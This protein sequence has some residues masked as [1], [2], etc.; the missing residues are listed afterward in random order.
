MYGA[1][2]YG[3]VPY[4]SAATS[5]GVYLVGEIALDP[6]ASITAAHGI[7]GPANIVVETPVVQ[8]GADQTERVSTVVVASGVAV[9]ATSTIPVY[10]VGLI[11]PA[12]SV[13]SLAW[14]TVRG[15][16]AIVAP[17]STSILCSQTMPITSNITA[18]VR[19][20]A[21]VYVD[22]AITAAIRP[23]V[24]AAAEGLVVTHGRGAV[25]I[26]AYVLST[27]T[28]GFVGS[29]SAT[30]RAVFSATA[31][32]SK[33]SDAAVNVPASVAGTINYGPSMSGAI[34]PAI[35]FY[36]MAGAYSDIQI[37]G[38]IIVPVSTYIRSTSGDDLLNADC[39]YV[40]TKQFSVSVLQ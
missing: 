40:L 39:A 6:V 11:G 25:T 30:I 36:A 33:M 38:A 37:S 20:S 1:L 10:A 34:S 23:I 16:A 32:H 2:S 18:K 3:Q 22:P 4:G 24:S 31:G 21:T 29:V 7:G 28:T 5:G 19:V 8:I 35:S 14:T 17:V 12:V 26:P 13:S 27:A 9:S 15:L